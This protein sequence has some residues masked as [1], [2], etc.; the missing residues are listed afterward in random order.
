MN[1]PDVGA[2]LGLVQLPK[3]DGFNARRRSLA[4]RYLQS[5]DMPVQEIA[6]MLGYSDVANFRRAFKRWE[7]VAPREYRRKRTI[8]MC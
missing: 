3:L 7:G 6:Y 8:R 1:L 5:R 2:A 4:L